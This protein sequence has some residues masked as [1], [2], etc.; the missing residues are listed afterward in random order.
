MGEAEAHE[1]R[2]YPWRL[3]LSLLVATG[4]WSGGRGNNGPLDRARRRAGAFKLALRRRRVHEEGTDGGQVS[5]ATPPLIVLR[6]WQLGSDRKKKKA[7]PPACW[8]GAVGMRW[9]RP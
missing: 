9:P 6:P 2:I 3:E 4:K 5:F 8:A 1:L 7:E